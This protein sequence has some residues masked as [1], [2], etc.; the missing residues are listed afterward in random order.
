MEKITTGTLRRYLF[1][2]DAYRFQIGPVL[3]LRRA[4]TQSYPGVRECWKHLDGGSPLTLCLI[5]ISQRH[6]GHSE[7][8]MPNRV[9]GIAFD[10]QLQSL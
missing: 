7:L 5:H 4:G 6:E 10:G 2:L 3:A 9:C 1:Q 8:I